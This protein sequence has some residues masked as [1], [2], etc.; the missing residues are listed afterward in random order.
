MTEEGFAGHPEEWW[1]FSW[2][3]QLWAKL[4]GAPAALYGLAEPSMISGASP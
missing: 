3:D 2:G 1:H 4:T